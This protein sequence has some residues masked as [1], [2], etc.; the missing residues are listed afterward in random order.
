MKSSSPDS[1]PNSSCFELFVKN[2]KGCK[3]DLIQGAHK[4]MLNV[5]EGSEPSPTNKVFIGLFNQ[6]TKKPIKD[7][8]F[9]RMTKSILQEL[10]LCILQD[11]ISGGPLRAAGLNLVVE[12]TKSGGK[13][14]VVQ[15]R[16]EEFPVDHDFVR[17]IDEALFRLTD[18]TGASPDKK[19]ASGA[20]LGP[21]YS[22]PDENGFFTPIKAKPK[23]LEQNLEVFNMEH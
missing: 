11:L 16:P 1:L 17:D 9:K 4:F 10:A 15:Q 18:L 12:E 19:V 6:F 14:V 3:P 20:G 21:P 23:S 8:V 22:P 13:T 2:P 7:Y 5:I